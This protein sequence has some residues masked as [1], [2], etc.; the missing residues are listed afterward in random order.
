[1]TNKPKLDLTG[2]K[3]LLYNRISKELKDLANDRRYYIAKK[4]NSRLK[5]VNKQ[6]LLF[7][8]TQKL[9]DEIFMGEEK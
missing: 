2:R 8:V 7:R 1:M 4:D 3:N 9:L 6:I 5:I